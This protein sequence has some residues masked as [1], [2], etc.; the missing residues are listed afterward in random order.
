MSEEF[1]TFRGFIEFGTSEYA[2]QVN[3]VAELGELTSEVR[4]ENETEIAQFW[5]YDRAENFFDPL[6]SGIK[7]P[8]KR[9]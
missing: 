2:E 7:S 8:K 9:F 1:W 4:T 6:D 3:E 5:S